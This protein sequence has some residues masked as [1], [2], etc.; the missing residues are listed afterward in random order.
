MTPVLDGPLVSGLAAHG[1]HRLNLRQKR[2]WDRVSL[3]PSLS[4]PDA[5]SGEAEAEGAYRF[6]RNPRVQSPAVLEPHLR[7]VADVGA[8]VVGRVLAVHDST[9]ITHS[10]FDDADDIYDLGGGKMGWLAHTSL[11]IEEDSGL[12]IG[13]GAFE[14][15]DRAAFQEAGRKE[16][17]RWWNG[18][19]SVEAR[20]EGLASC[21]HVM[22]SE[23]DNYLMLMNLVEAGYD[24]VV[25]ASQDRRVRPAPG[26]PMMLM[27][28]ALEGAEVFTGIEVDIKARKA[29]RR[30]GKGKR[31]T[32]ARAHRTAKLSVRAIDI[33]LVRA[34]KLPAKFAP[35]LDLRLVHVVEENPPAGEVPID[36][37]LWTTLP[38]ESTEDALR[39][40]QIYKRR[41][42]IEEFFKVM[43]SHCRHSARHFESRHTSAN[44]FALFVPLAA[45]HLYLRG[46][47][48]LAPKAKARDYFPP[49]HLTAICKLDRRA[50][51]N[52][53]VAAAIN[54]LARIG[55]HLKSNGPPGLQIIGRA[56]AKVIG[57]A[58]GW[59]AATQAGTTA[60]NR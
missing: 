41:W 60:R 4:I 12:P 25:R 48:R 15:L 37:K 18:V 21:I 33:Q 54:A 28:K 49:A 29:S 57:F 55:G 16:S 34:K 42:V 39:V 44:A 43:K 58:E 13:V 26:A 9:A 8:A 36:W 5:V 52:M 2:V 10:T 6:L 20:R 17:E 40:V 38:V 23:G 59:K 11:L 56:L 30:P 22:D 53:T 46:I 32:R 51:S 35:H 1:D 50:R 45:Y 14:E 19:V 27:S 24:F 3:N 31:N 47:Q 7:A